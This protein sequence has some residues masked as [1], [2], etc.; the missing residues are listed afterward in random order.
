MEVNADV[1][2]VTAAADK[3]LLIHADQGDFL[4]HIDFQS[5]PDASLPRRAHCYNALLE[6]RHGLPV[7]IVV[8]LLRPEAN[9]KVINGLYR[10]WLPTTG[11]P[12]LQFRY[13]LVRVWELPVD[14]LLQAGL[15]ML[16]WAPISAVSSK[17]L[18]DVIAR[19]EQRLKA[20]ADPART[21]EFWTATK[22]FLGLRYEAEFVEQLLH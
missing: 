5:G 22:V 14:R 2:T 3:V 10:H 9:L 16:P 11:E 7:E 8:V 17:D 19:M 21:G 6:E 4:Q 15:G 1:S 18:P 20:E 13:R 12:Y